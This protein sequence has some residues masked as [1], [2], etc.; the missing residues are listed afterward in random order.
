MNNCPGG[1]AFFVAV[2]VLATTIVFSGGVAEAA[3]GWQADWDKTVEAARREGQVTVYT[4]DGQAPILNSGAFQKRFPD[5]KLVYI[6]TRGNTTEQRLFSERRAG[7]YLADLAIHGGT[8]NIEF[9]RAKA[10]DPIKPTLLLPDVVDESKW[11]QGKHPYVDP[12]E[13][14]IFRHIGSAQ[15]FI[16]GYNSNL[17]DPKEFRTLRDVLNPKW[18]GK[19]V[20]FDIRGGA[21]GGWPIRLLYHHPNYG[22]EFI[23]EFFANMNVVLSR[24]NRQAI[25]WV[26][27]GK[28]S[29]CFLCGTGPLERAKIQGLPVDVLPMKDVVAIAS[30]GGTIGLLNRA[31]HPNAT[32]VFLN[33]LL[34]RE[35]QIV[36]QKALSQNGSLSNS[37]RIDI[38]KDDVPALERRVEGAQYI[39]VEHP[40]RLDMRPIFKI[41]EE[42]L[43]DRGR[44][45]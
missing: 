35:G 17:V 24:D 12:E 33:W 5:I 42:S 10:L 40:S 9:Q 37:M 6:F 15:P 43:R 1:F 18:K 3:P 19:F 41:M 22:P 23:R 8:N 29:F 30:Q 34:S 32:K 13:R 20:A 14:Y 2:T 11:W 44:Q 21:Y 28:Y 4:H 27:T 25:D 39:E 26:A 7:R 16:F 45:K 31:P 36:A 38:P